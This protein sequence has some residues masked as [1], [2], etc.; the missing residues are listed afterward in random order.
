MNNID[1]A[2]KTS[3]I[4]PPPLLKG[5]IATVVIATLGSLILAAAFCFTTMT[6]PTM[7]ALQLPL[8]A[9]A[10]FIGAF[11]AAKAAGRKGL[12]HGVRQGILLLVLMLLFTLLGGSF[13]LLAL[14]LKGLIILAASAMGG[15]LGVF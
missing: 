10:A 11:V 9:L 15:I 12:M 4:T 13:G 3:G 5:A 6:D 8:L 14:L 1:I 2:A 7:H